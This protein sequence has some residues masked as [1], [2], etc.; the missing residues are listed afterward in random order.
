MVQTLSYVLAGILEKG[1]IRPLLIKD[2]S[3]S[4]TVYSLRLF[5]EVQFI[6]FI[7]K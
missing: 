3:I 1:S 6:N 5:A 2:C 7:T 4:C